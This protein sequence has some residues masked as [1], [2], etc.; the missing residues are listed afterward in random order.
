MTEL[1]MRHTPKPLFTKIDLMHGEKSI[2][3]LQV[4]DLTMRI[5]RAR[6]RCGGIGAVGTDPEWRGRGLSRRVIEHAMEWMAEQGYQVS[7]LFG[8]PDYYPKYGFS[9]ALVDTVISMATRDLESAP[10]RFKARRMAPEDAPA[11]L[12]LYEHNRGRHTGSMVRDPSVWKRFRLGSS[13][14]D[15]VGAFVLCEGDEIV[16][17]ASYNLDYWRYGIGEVGYRDASVFDGLLA[18]IGRRAVQLCVERVPITTPLDDPFCTHCRR[19]GC[20]VKTTYPRQ[21]GGMVRIIDQAS[22]LEQ[23]QPVLAER[24]ERSGLGWSGKLT[25][26]TELGAT[27]LDLGSGAESIDLAL[28]QTLLTQWLL[29]Y[30]DIVEGLDAEDKTLDA[31]TVSLLEVLFPMGQP[32]V[33]LADRF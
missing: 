16:G 26:S 11:V 23:V 24:L 33:W 1:T 6:V 2:S 4:W 8:I 7:A 20:E 13:W 31:E 28:P 19:Y 27:T 10:Q 5:D 32:H 30:R 15:R 29:G 21:G 25:L 22:T 9:V 12:A 14:T 3:R 18:E 17:Y